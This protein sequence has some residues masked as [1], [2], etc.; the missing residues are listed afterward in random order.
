MIL[1]NTRRQIL[2][3]KQVLTNEDL[4]AIYND[5]HNLEESSIKRARIEIN[6]QNIQSFTEDGWG[7]ISI[8]EIN[9]R[10]LEIIGDP[11]LSRN[12]VSTFASGAATIDGFLLYN[13][14]GG[15][16]FS[17][18]V[19]FPV[20]GDEGYYTTRFTLVENSQWY[21]R[22]GLTAETS[23]GEVQPSDEGYAGAIVLFFRFTPVFMGEGVDP[24]VHPDFK[25]WVEFDYAVRD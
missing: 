17:L 7:Q 13:G 10:Y 3:N 24:V 12:D 18:N 21:Y 20:G 2:K 23:F 11:I 22:G 25:A 16:Q 5:L 9:G 19:N 6:A 1:P 8:P 15:K 14:F 4:T